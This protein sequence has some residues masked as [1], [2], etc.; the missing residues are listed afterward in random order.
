[1][2]KLYDKNERYTLEALDVT[3]ELVDTLEKL[4][5]GFVKN[6]YSIRELCGIA[7]ACV[8]EVE[9]K[10]MLE[11]GVRDEQAKAPK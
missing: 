4:L 1:M 9:C 7:H 10:L 8:S 2:S 3:Q 6:G 11:Q 5:A